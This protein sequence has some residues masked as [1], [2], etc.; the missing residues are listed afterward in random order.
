MLLLAA[1]AWLRLQPSNNLLPWTK[2]RTLSDCKLEALL[3][4]VAVAARQASQPVFPVVLAAVA[5]L[6]E[7]GKTSGTVSA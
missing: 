5:A 6:A 7:A 4:S 1:E 2:R 3:A